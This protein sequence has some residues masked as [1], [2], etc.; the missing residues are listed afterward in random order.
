MAPK[1]LV[2][3]VEKF[4]KD[5][6][7]RH[8]AQMVA[9][10]KV[11]HD[12][13]LGTNAFEPHEIALIDLP[14]CQRLRRISQT[15][16]ASLIYPS[17]NHNR[18]EHSLGV[19][20]IAGKIL[21][22]LRQRLWPGK[23][24]ILSSAAVM[25]VRTAAILHDI[26]QGPFS[27]LT[28]YI[29][30]QLPEV[31]RYRKK[32]PNKFSEDKPHEMLSYLIVKSPTFQDYVKHEIVGKYARPEINID[33]IAEM[34][35]AAGERDPLNAW[36]GNIINGP[37]DADKLDYLQRDAYFSG[38]RIGIDLD[39]FLNSV[40]LDWSSR[41]RRLKVMTSG[42]ITLEQILFG[43]VL[44]YNTMYHHQKVLAAECAIQGIFEM[45]R[46]HP[47]YKINGRRMDRVIDY[48]YITEEAILSLD[49][50]PE[51]LK[52]YID[53]FLRRDLLKRALVI[54]ADTVNKPET[55]TGYSQFKDLVEDPDGLRNLRLKLVSALNCKYPIYDIWIVLPRTPTFSD[56]ASRAII[57]DPGGKPKSLREPFR[58]DEWLTAY[59]SNKWKGYVF[60]PAGEAIRKEVAK[61]AAEL[62]HDEYKFSLN[63]KAMEQAKI[64]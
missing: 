35:V 46:D 54:S 23:T 29:M 32:N 5:L 7:S 30:K 64:R 24:D 53:R 42:A 55:S 41:P 11:I 12:P 4:V 56:E 63:S 1:S 52:N 61:K 17:A 16:V 3:D 31:I 18:L 40:W 22:S 20:T 37:F 27:H 45:L 33:R 43:K 2:T 25:E 57:Q 6:F 36:Q 28:D 21:D 34:I 47:D 49:N 51:E 39:R 10:R 44:L 58:V 48:L 14:F 62:F 38:L 50:K 59:W 15:D 13:I 26:G 19:A 9:E 8:P 60:C